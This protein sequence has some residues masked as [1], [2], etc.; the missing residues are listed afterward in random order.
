MKRAYTTQFGY[1]WQLF[2]NGNCT[3]VIKKLFLP[4]KKQFLQTFVII[5]S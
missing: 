2:N 3:K 1:N 4:G 5:S